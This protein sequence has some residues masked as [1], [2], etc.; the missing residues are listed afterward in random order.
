MEVLSQQF[1]SSAGSSLPITLGTG[2]L[3]SIPASRRLAASAHSASILKALAGGQASFQG[4]HLY[5]ARDVLSLQACSPIWA[6]S[7]SR[8]PCSKRATQSNLRCKHVRHNA[9][10]SPDSLVDQRQRRRIF[11]DF[12]SSA[13]ELWPSRFECLL[14]QRG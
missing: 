14:R 3:G 1:G 13:P 11:K 9:R 8:R 2:Y 10:S 6:T 7:L 4:L 12:R 5:L